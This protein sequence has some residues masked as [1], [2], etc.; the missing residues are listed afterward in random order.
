MREVPKI[1]PRYILNHRMRCVYAAAFIFLALTLAACAS[2]AGGPTD[3]EAEV[4]GIP[5]GF[6]PEGYPYRG[7]IN[8]PIQFIEYSDYLCPFCGQH[9]LQTAP[10]LEEQYVRT[11][12]VVHIFRDFPIASLHPTAPLGHAAALCVAEQGA[13]PFWKM[14]DQLFQNQEQ[15]RNLPDPSEYLSN[16]AENLGVNM[17]DYKECMES[18]RTNLAVQQSVDYAVQE[19]GF[20]AT[21]SF[22]FVNA[23]SGEAYTLVGAYPFEKFSQYIEALLAGQQPPEE[24]TAEQEEPE[25]PYWANED[26]LKP[27]PNRPGFT[28]AGDPY[29]GD[30]NAPMVVVEFSN[31]QCE[32]CIK[33]HQT[34][35]PSVEAQFIQTGE[36]MWV[37]KNLLLQSLP[38]SS[39]AA[40]AAECA[41]EQGA[42]WEMHDLLYA[43]AEKWA[44][45]NPDPSLIS[46]ASTLDLDI[47]AFSTCL[48]SREALEK[49]LTD[50]FDAQGIVD[51]TPTFIAIYGGAGRVIRGAK[52]LDEFIN[53]LKQLLEKAKE[54]K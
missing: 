9:F 10:L 11:G 38:Q 12:K 1:L 13:A 20:N 5:V 21:P 39:A 42:F 25:L 51:T 4:N 44:L 27:D 45:E 54:T 18:G 17:K 14:H 35:Q 40:V 52:E 19:M 24:K 22:Q 15:W 33:Y 29:K 34:V 37:F 30:P 6:T 16:L 48:G 47:D 53:L 3:Q 43:N 23:A 7:N 46:L 26:G 36:I 8:A 28:M 31:F 32:A 50:M 2:A 49:V 41:G